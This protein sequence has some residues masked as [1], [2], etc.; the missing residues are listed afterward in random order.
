[1]ED[2]IKVIGEF[3]QATKMNL[4]EN[5]PNYSCIHLLDEEA[6]TVDI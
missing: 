4:Q 5:L 2:S 3:T 1:M 6:E